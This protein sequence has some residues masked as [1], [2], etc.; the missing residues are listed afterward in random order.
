MFSPGMVADRIKGLAKQNGVSVGA[1]LSECQ[2][3][4]NALSSMQSGGFMPRADNI[5]K[6]ADYLDCSVDYLLG[7][8]DVVEVGGGAVVLSDDEEVLLERYRSLSEDG[9]ELV[10]SRALEIM[11]EENY[12]R[13]DMEASN[14][15]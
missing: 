2:I 8:T 13:G 7:R 11:R 4:K 10:R 5:G 9:Q 12:A 15:G 1:M 14:A 3:S 6:I